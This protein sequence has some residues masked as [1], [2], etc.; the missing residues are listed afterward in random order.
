[1]IARRE[2]LLGAASLVADR[3]AAASG[4]AL[5]EIERRANGRLGV[6][7]LDTGTGARLSHRGG[8]RFALLSTF[9]VLA[10][11]LILKRVDTGED[12]LDRHV[13]YH[14]SDLVAYS[15]ET[16]KNVASGMTL[17]A[18]CEASITLSDNTAGNLMLASF[19][20]PPALTAF[21]RALGDPVTRLDR[22]ETALNEARPGDP[23]DTTSPDAMADTLRTLLVGDALSPNSRRQLA[24]WMISSKT[25]DARL[26]AG[27][28]AGWRCGDKTGT[29][30][31]TAND[32]AIIWPPGRSPLIV[33]SYL[34]ESSAMP[35]DK[36]A[37]HA[38]VGRIA[39]AWRP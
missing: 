2:F 38:E 21:M 26:R 35:M 36:N 22:I 5:S 23:R 24:G 10:A 37:A 17:A 29:S 34:A 7:I 4:T 12:K 3:S 15:P 28:P 13:T 8:E 33:A 19:G 14:E 20:G 9:K 11:A 31:R 6:T 27:L 1:M 16:K 30:E 25:G 18:I 39:A 32:V